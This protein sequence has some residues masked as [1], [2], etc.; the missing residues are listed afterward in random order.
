MQKTQLEEPIY[1][2]PYAIRMMEV[3][4]KSILS[5]TTPTSKEFWEQQL[6]IWST[7]RD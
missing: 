6:V 1:T 4:K 7:R 5:V 3:C 2:A